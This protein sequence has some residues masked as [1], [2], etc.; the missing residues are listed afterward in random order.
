MAKAFEG[1]NEQRRAGIHRLADAQSLLS[2]GRWRGSM[3]MAGYA[4]EC[5]PKTK[6]MVKFDCPTLTELDIELRRRG[7]LAGGDSIYSHHLEKMLSLTERHKAIKRN[8]ILWRQ[9]VVVNRWSAPWRYDS[10]PSS[11]DEAE[12]FLSAVDTVAGWIGSNI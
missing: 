12:T 4:I 7:L 3:Y 9:F 5:L 11:Q 6:Q 2:Q 10:R 1:K 8:I